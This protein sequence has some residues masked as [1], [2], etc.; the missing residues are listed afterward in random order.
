[1]LA[2]KIILSYSS[3]T[4][5]QL[6]QMF[7]GLIVARIAGPSVIGT[8]AFGSAY[9]SIWLFLSDLGLGTAHI[10]HISEGKDL[11]TSNATYFY[12]QSGAIFFYTMFVIGI[13]GVQKYVLL[14]Q[15]ESS[16][17]E[18]V[19]F[20]TLIS[21]IINQF[22]LIPRNTFA[23]KVQQAKQDI[24]DITQKI[25]FQTLRLSVVLLGYRAIAIAFSKVIAAS[26]MIPF[27][28]YLFRNEAIGKFSKEKVKNYFSISLPVIIITGIGSFLN[29]FDKLLLQHLTNSEELGYYTAAFAICGFIKLIGYS[30]GNIFFPIFSKAIAENN[31]DLINSYISKFERFSMI[32]VFPF[33]IL[34]SIES[35]F[36]VVLMLGEKFTP[37]IPIFSI[38]IYATFIKVFT[39]PY[40]NVLSGKG[41]FRL[42][43]IFR[44]IQLFFFIPIAFILVSPTILNLKSSGLAMAL[45]LTNIFFGILIIFY[46]FKNI[47]QINIFPSSKVLM[48]NLIFGISSFLIYHYI[49]HSLF[50]KIVYS[51]LFLCFFWGI[52]YLIQIIKKEDV[53]L[54]KKIFNTKNIKNYIENELKT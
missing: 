42:I 16:T 2:Q 51:I 29:W 47:P 8:V 45:L 22:Y 40:A 14:Y 17:H 54:I 10:K 52:G 5:M 21:V 50:S 12:L 25:I 9:V 48:F 13:Y 7:V 4:F 53:V 39:I 18:A 11:A 31:I 23:G 46:I 41:L 1:M 15:F 34:A 20:I 35:D 37:T 38:V 44:T 24:P 32:F 3:R 33:I 19:I 28:L 26:L 36:I 43:A 49:I 6:I 27:F 30:V